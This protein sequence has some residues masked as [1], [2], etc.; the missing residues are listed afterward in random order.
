MILMME[1]TARRRASIHRMTS[2]HKLA[3]SISHDVFLKSF[4]NSQFPHKSVSLS[5]ILVMMA[6]KLT[7]LLGNSFLQNNTINTFCEIKAKVY[8]PLG[9]FRGF[10]PTEI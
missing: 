2:G 8:V 10:C 5:F 4:C 6:V 7:D 9:E 1:A 3:N